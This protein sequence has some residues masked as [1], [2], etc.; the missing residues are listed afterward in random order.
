MRPEFSRL[1]LDI[2]PELEDNLALVSRNLP[3]PFMDKSIFFW[4]HTHPED[5]TKS[6]SRYTRLLQRS[7]VMADHWARVICVAG[8][9]PSHI[10][11]TTFR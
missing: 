9:N 10:F 4:S 2:Y 11:K 5:G 1:L 3:L 7:V 6:Q 8:L